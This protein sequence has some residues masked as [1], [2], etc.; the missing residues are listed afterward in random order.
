ME[1]KSV[2][3]NHRLETQCRNPSKH[4]SLLT[5]KSTI[6][7]SDCTVVAVFSCL[8]CGDGEGEGTGE[9]TGDG[10]GDGQGED[11]AELEE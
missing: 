6:I 11:D 3:A 1:R 10:D 5:T 7:S 2:G 8:R 4:L 9:G